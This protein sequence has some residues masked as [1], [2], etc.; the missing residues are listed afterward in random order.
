MEDSKSREETSTRALIEEEEDIP[1][2]EAIF[3]VEAE[4]GDPHSI[5][6]P[7]TALLKTPIKVFDPTEHNTEENRKNIKKNN[8][9]AHR[10]KQ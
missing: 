3:L 2:A 6:S 4:A 10:K 7:T 8:R 9:K 5:S 1:M